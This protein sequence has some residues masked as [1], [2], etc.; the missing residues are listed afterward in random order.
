MDNIIIRKAT[1]EDAEFLAQVVVMAIR[2]DEMVKQNCGGDDYLKVLAEVCEATGTQYSYQN[3]LV[4]ETSDGKPAGAIL[5]YDGAELYPLRRATWKIISNHT[6]FVPIM[7]DE[8]EAGEFYLDSLAIKSEYRG[9]GLGQKLIAAM[10]EKAFKEG[11][12]N[13]GL[14]VDVEN[15]KAEELYSR[16]G[17]GRVGE[18]MFFTHKMYHL[19]KTFK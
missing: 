11:H 12:N 3:A 7:A 6:G 18:R 16:I 5:G 17:F 8:T 19:Q 9:M 10:T 2:D 14:I 15:P 4:A 1:P 13:V